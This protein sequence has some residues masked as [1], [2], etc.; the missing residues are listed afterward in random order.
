MWQGL[1][2]GVWVLILAGCL[3]S[4]PEQSIIYYQVIS[5]ITE[6]RTEK[7]SGC[8][9]ITEEADN[10]KKL[11]LQAKNGD[12]YYFDIPGRTFVQSLDVV[13]PTITPRPTDVILPTATQTATHP[14]PPPPGQL[15]AY[16][17]P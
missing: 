16:P 5:G 17:N 10:G 14:Y 11:V 3:K 13:A 2:N 7:K 9:T 4:D 6:I 8:L 1:D 12:T 15:Q